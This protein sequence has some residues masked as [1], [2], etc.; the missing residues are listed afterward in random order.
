[1]KTVEADC[2]FSHLLQRLCNEMGF[3]LCTIIRSGL[4]G[5]LIS[6]APSSRCPQG[7][8]SEEAIRKVPRKA[9]ETGGIRELYNSRGIK[10]NSDF[11]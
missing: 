11:I 7:Q 1:M 10:I 2:V 5:S 4:I 3:L 6:A 8:L 9:Q